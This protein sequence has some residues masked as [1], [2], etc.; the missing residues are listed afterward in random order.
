LS[1][2]TTTSS[3]EQTQ[4]VKIIPVGLQKDQGVSATIASAESTPLSGIYLSF[5]Y[6]LIYI[7]ISESTPANLGSTEIPSISASTVETLISESTL[8]PT[9]VSLSGKL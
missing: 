8:Q 6:Q 2:E 9:T 3:S 7:E 5:S 1:I 4:E